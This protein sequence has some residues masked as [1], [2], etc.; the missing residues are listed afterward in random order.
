MPASILLHKYIT[1]YHF[2]TSTLS[3]Y[4]HPDDDISSLQQKKI[5]RIGREPSRTQLPHLRVY[6]VLYSAFLPEDISSKTFDLFL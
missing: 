3:P 1:S 5:E 4:L 6:V 2:Q